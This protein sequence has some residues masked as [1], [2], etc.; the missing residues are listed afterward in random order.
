M[1]H[2]IMKGRLSALDTETIGGYAVILATEY[3]TW[4]AHSFEECVSPIFMDIHNQNI[5][6][7]V[8]M[9]NQK[10]DSQAI[11]KYLP[12][13]NVWEILDTNETIYADRYK[14]LYIPGKIIRIRDMK[15]KETL[16]GYDIAQFY[17][18][19]HLDDAGL[20][21]VE[22]GKFNSG[23]TE[24]ITTNAELQTDEEL[25]WVFGYHRDEIKRY[26]TEDAKLTQKLGYYLKNMIIEMFGFEVSSY[27]A[28]TVIGRTLIKN[29]VGKDYPKFLLESTAGKLARMAYHGGIFDCKKRGMFGE[30]T[31]IDISSAYP[32]HQKE[33]PHWANGNFIEVEACEIRDT[34][35]YGWVWCKFDYPLIPYTV[36]ENFTWDEVH[37]E[38]VQIVS[39]EGLRKYYPNGDRWQPITLL[40]AR[41]LEKYGYLKDNI[42]GVIWRH[43]PKKHQYPNPFS[44]INDVYKL[45]KEVKATEGK[46]SYKYDLTKKAMNSSY[47]VTAQKKG[48]A[49]YRN[50][51]YAS[52]ITAATR[53]QICEMLE[54]IGYDSY[55]SIATDGILLEGFVE[56][57]ERFIKSGLGSWD[58]TH[59]DK[60]LVLANGI[61]QLEK[62]GKE[63]KIATRGMLSFKGDLKV[64]IMNNRF[65]TSIIPNTARRPVT[66]YQ[67]MRWKR[68]T[69]DDMNRFVSITR[70]LSCNTDS[71]K[72]W[73]DIQ[74][75]DDL[76]SRKYTGTRFTIDELEGE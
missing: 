48:Y 26:C 25:F 27:S 57:P 55:I 62:R 51:F 58:V 71:S 32:F 60:A 40:E 4:A 21:Y 9:W 2:R 38:K 30:C 37:N 12:D 49:Q 13:V 16:S 33:L 52:Y 14:I 75:F 61:Y 19:M 10:Y 11:L 1:G 70:K 17:N 7:R 22:Q 43:N 68:Y 36:D 15:L 28:K 44:W 8:L 39:A 56:V 18:Y 59:W 31:D 54:E 73:D 50:F 24:C 69:K 45:K 72:K 53:I 67:A 76:L 6:S 29:T 5:S 65:E 34:D 20:R 64:L 74:T 42:G 41:F 35:V 66:M 47:G 46:D 23:V 3:R 63:P